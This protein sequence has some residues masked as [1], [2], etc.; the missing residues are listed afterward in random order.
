MAFPLDPDSARNL[1]LR[2][3]YSDLLGACQTNTYLNSICRG[4][5]LW[6]MMVARDFG[7][8]IIPYKPP[9][10]SFRQQY[11]DLRNLRDTSTSTTRA[12]QSNRLDI[13]LIL[14]KILPI[15]NYWATQ[16]AAG[17]GNIPLLDWY[18][19]RGHLDDRTANTAAETG[20]LD[21]LKWLKE[22]SILPSPFAID[23][24]R[25]AGRQQVVDWLLQQDIRTGP[26]PTIRL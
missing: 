18:Y 13:L 10:I 12:V 17:Y 25:E 9:N 21:V 6:R 4:D 23:K 20:Q 16:V 22:R 14:E 2:L 11:E 3:E 8:E 1:L 19:R 5:D 24:A 15:T 7:P 26:M